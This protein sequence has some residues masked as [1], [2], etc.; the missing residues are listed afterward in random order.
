MGCWKVKC[1]G[2]GGENVNRSKGEERGERREG[3]R[4]GGGEKRRREEGEG[5]QPVGAAE[6]GK[7]W[8]IKVRRR[9]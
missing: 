4:R 7:Q 6:E 9:I 3:E 8:K 5:W 1:E 2:K